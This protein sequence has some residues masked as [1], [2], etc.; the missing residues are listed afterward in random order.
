MTLKIGKYL[1]LVKDAHEKRG[2][3]FGQRDVLKTTTAKRIRE[4]MTSDIRAG[5]VLPPVVVGLVVDKELLA[6]LIEKNPPD[7][8]HFIKLAVGK[9]L[10][11]IDGMQRT[12]SLI[13]AASAEPSVYARGMRVEFW[14]AQ[15]VRALIYRMLVLNTGQV[16][17]TLSR[18]LSVVY[19]PLLDEIKKNVKNLGRVFTPDKP[20]RRVG[21]AEFSSESL[22]EL[23][24][25][26]SLR[27]VSIDTRES[28]SDEFS[29]LDFVENLGNEKFQS[30]FYDVLSILAE[31]D[32]CF[33]SYEGKTGTRFT[34]GR[35]IFGSQPARIG[36]VVAVAQHILGRPGLDRSLEEQSA[37]MEA[38]VMESTALIDRLKPLDTDGLG[39]F[40]MLDV[41]SEILDKRV[42]QVGRYER[43]VFYEAFRLLVNEHF[44]VPSLE[45]CWRA[46]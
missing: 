31:L 8:D 24:L 21:G 9:T 6:S 1:E 45:P 23:Y 11:I 10:S 19:A 14:V 32:T 20:G 33:D 42:G 41:L 35:D 40:L 18:Q 15:S 17:W 2:A 7:E 3:I 29:R 37:R 13:E 39:N 16:P 12:G 38:M 46:S 36:F 44:N 27:K 4:R 34:R 30:H 25:A 5:A 28:L 26:F 22:V 43:A